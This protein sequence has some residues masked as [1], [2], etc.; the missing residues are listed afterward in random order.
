MQH[1]GRHPDEGMLKCFN[2]LVEWLESECAAELYTLAELH[3]K[4]VELSDEVEVYT[5]KRLKQKLQEHYQEHIF[6]ANVQG[7]DCFKNMAKFIINEKWQ[8]S[9]IS[10]ED[11][12][13]WIISTA[14][15][16]VRDEIQEKLY[17]T[18][19]YPSNEDI[20]SSSQ[21]SQWIPHHLQI[22]FSLLLFQ[23]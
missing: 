4:M 16:I 3:S 1:T 18:K 10:T 2:S 20:S 9:R 13:E 19:F 12:A 17:D 21:N 5:I 8:S 11:K 7:R 23:K 6:F 22:S 15:K 14:A